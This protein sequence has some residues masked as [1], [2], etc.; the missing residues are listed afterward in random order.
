MGRQPTSDLAQQRRLLDMLAKRLPEG[1]N[2]VLH[3]D[4]GWHNTSTTGGEAA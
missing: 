4:M 3:S 2:P 1:A